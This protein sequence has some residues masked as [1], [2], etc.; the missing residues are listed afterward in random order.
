MNLAPERR[1]L[2]A[3]LASVFNLYVIF[4][5]ELRTLITIPLMI[6]L[7]TMAIVSGYLLSKKF[8]RG[9]FRN[10]LHFM[11][12]VL[13]PAI[14]HLL[15]TI[16]YY[17]S[18]NP[19]VETYSCKQGFQ[20]E[21]RSSAYE[22]SGGYHS[23]T[24]LSLEGGAYNDFPGIRVFADQSQIKGQSITYTFADGLFGLRVMRDWE[25]EYQR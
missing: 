5:I 8:R 13:F 2:I 12:W 18:F 23:N 22:G 4:R 11:G 17:V 21:P 20:Y 7:L 1:A 24:M 14:L 25:F 15:F 16:N 3:S 10:Y 6:L 9:S 19:K